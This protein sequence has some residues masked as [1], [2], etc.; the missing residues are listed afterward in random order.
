[1]AAHVPVLRGGGVGG[2]RVDGGGGGGGGGDESPLPMNAKALE[3]DNNLYAK[4]V[5]WTVI[6]ARELGVMPP[7]SVLGWS[8]VDTNCDGFPSW[9]TRADARTLVTAVSTWLVAAAAR[10]ELGGERNIEARRRVD[11]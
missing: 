10:I 1:M 11:L 4:P 7:A 9:A 3:D 6:H 2:E 5:Y 8:R